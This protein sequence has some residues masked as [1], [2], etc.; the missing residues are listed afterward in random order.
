M[1]RRRIKFTRVQDVA[2]EVGIA[3]ITLRRWLLAGKVPEVRRDRNRWR[4]FT[5]A[6]IA[7]IKRFAY[8]IDAGNKA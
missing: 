8:R 6:D 7:R 5:R 3:P 1:A 2:E 4:I